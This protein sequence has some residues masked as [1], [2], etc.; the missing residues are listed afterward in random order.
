MP[1]LVRSACSVVA[2]ALIAEQIDLLR[3]RGFFSSCSNH[4]RVAQCLLQWRCLSVCLSVGRPICLSSHW[5]G[6]YPTHETVYNHVH[7]RRPANIM[8]I[9]RQKVVWMTAKNAEYIEN[10]TAEASHE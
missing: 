3:N 2:R 6:N 7:L 4:R 9:K 10:D 1:C 8:T 5:S